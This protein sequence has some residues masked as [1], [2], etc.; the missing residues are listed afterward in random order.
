M[1]ASVTIRIATICP[2]STPWGASQSATIY[3]PGIIL[4]S[5]SSHGGFKLDAKRNDAMPTALRLAGGWYEE[6]GEWAR[7]ATAFPEHFTE[8]ELE[9]ADRIL[10]DW[11]PDAWEAMH[12][13]TLTAQDSFTRDREQFGRDNAANWVVI[14]ASRSSTHEGQIEA[15]ATIGGA[16]NSAERRVFLVP[17]EAYEPGRHGYVIDP[18]AHPRI[19]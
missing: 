11:L 9:Q 15:L 14:S 17:R 7:V 1:S 12:G 18:L 3:A 13:R 6:D 19:E 5:T 10:R 16:R 8:Y 4:H 2:A